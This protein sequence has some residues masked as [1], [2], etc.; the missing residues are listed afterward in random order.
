MEYIR[1]SLLITP[2]SLWLNLTVFT[3]GYMIYLFSDRTK[4]INTIA[5]KIGING[6]QQEW[7][8]YLQKFLGFLLLGV[9]PFIMNI[10]IG[11]GLGSVGFSLPH[12]TNFLL[13]CLIPILVFAIIVVF[14]SK[15]NIPIHFYPQ[16]R[17]PEWNR[18]RI[19]FNSFFWILYLIAYEFAFRGFLLFPMISEYGFIMAV[20]I[21]SS[22]YALA[23][24]YKG[25]GEAFGAFFLGILL[26]VIAVA[27][28]SFLI[29]VIIHIIL[30]IGNDMAAVAEN[31][32]M[33]FIR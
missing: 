31:P 20:V 4:I 25:P 13:W 24:I 6:S 18:K 1:E 3:L 8:V 5:L 10:I 21:N 30:A 17:Q 12:G 23:H 28:N 33:E 2:T 27:T 26:C 14:R 29:P 9:I 15:K 7:V 19:I 22:I 32:E 11:E 16:V